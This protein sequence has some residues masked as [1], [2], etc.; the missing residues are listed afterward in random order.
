MMNTLAILL[1]AVV[2]TASFSVTESYAFDPQ[3]IN[4]TLTDAQIQNFD[5][6]DIFTLVISLFNGGDQNVTIAGNSALYLNDTNSDYWEYINH[7]DYEEFTETDCPGLDTT[8]SPN[9]TA[10]VQLC[11]LTFNDVDI[12]YSLVLEDGDYSTGTQPN[13]IVLE[14]V[15]NWFKT[16]AAS[17]CSNA[18]TESQFIT[19]VQTNIQDGTINVL[20]GQSGLD[21]GAQTPEWIKSNSCLWST[22][23]ISDYEFLDGIYWLVDNGKIQ[24]N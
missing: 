14:S 11:Y 6:Y 24:L 23:Q 12:G 8:I 17:W 2:I 18:I 5:G 15:P 3:T 16:T 10:S 22:D 19:L 1:L 4:I 9:S 21:T 20:R 7:Q 13:E